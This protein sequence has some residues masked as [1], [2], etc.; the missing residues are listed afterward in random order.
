MDSESEIWLRSGNWSRNHNFLLRLFI[1]AFSLFVILLLVQILGNTLIRCLSILPQGVQWSV[2]HFQ[3]SHSQNFSG[4]NSDV[5]GYF[6]NS[7]HFVSYLLSPVLWLSEILL[8][9]LMLRKH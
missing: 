1:S 9:P 4:F 5:D 6:D 7:A 2:T 3:N 8:F